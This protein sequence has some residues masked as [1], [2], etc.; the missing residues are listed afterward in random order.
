MHIIHHFSLTYYNTYINSLIGLSL[1]INVQQLA[2]RALA[3]CVHM[4]KCKILVMKAS[5]EI[6]G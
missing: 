6:I 3:M 2:W 5:S 4:K 1:W